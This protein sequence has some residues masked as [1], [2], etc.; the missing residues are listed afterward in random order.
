MFFYLYQ[1]TNLVNNKIYIGVH[2]TKDMNDSY[3]GSGINIQL[4]IKKYG[5]DNFKKDILYTFDNADDMYAKEKDIVTDEFLL[6]EDTYN[7]RVGG[8]GGFD[9]INKNNL[10]GFYDSE[11]AR[12]GRQSTNAV[13]KERYGEQWRKVI[14]KNGNKALHKKR[15][16]DPSFNQLMI[17]H[18][19]RN[20]KI[21]S[22]YANTSLAIEK[23]KNTF[24]KIGHQQGSKNSQYGKMWITNGKESRSIPSQETIPE[25]WRRGR[26][27]IPKPNF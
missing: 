7:L 16:D 4:A 8:T 11:T 21:A 10:N 12:K 19:R 2:S 5:I 27:R 13:L 15:E 22:Q 26:V 20:V 24:S 25:G 17:E 6:R 3:M 14:S 9:Y 1:I 18:S 23:K